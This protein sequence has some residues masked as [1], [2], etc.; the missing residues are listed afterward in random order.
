M[1]SGRSYIQDP[2]YLIDKMKRITKVREGFFIVTADLIG[3]YPSTPHKE[4]IL[5][6]GRFHGIRRIGGICR[7]L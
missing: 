2:G 6:P 7:K 3:L 1:Q 5:G 4:R